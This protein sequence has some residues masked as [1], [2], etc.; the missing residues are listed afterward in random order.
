ML[1]FGPVSSVF[2]LITFYVLVY[3]FGVGEALFQ[4]GGFIES[5]TTQ[6]LVVFAIRTRGPIFPAQAALV[7]AAMALVS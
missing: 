3:L 5:I 6:V 4:T 2:D 7:L 1:V